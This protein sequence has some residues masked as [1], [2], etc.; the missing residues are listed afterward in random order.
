M[1]EAGVRTAVAGVCI[2]AG[3]GACTGAESTSAHSGANNRRAVSVATTA[4]GDLLANRMDSLAALLDPQ[5]RRQSWPGPAVMSADFALLSQYFGSCHILGN[6]TIVSPGRRPISTT[7]NQIAVRI[8][9]VCQHHSSIVA[10]VSVTPANQVASY[11]LETSAS[12]S[13]QV[14]SDYLMIDNRP[15]LGGSRADS[16]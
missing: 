1:R 12:Q 2:A 4:V 5:F 9:V 7:A 14:Q 15:V 11:F 10:G 3:L 8:P 16:G 13:I 6:P